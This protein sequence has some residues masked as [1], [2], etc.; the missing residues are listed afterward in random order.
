MR[1]LL[2]LLDLSDEDFRKILARGIEHAGNRKLAPAA[3]ADRTVTLLFEKTS[4]RTRLSFSVAV[5][6]MGGHLIALESQMLQV[7]RGE[8]IEDTTEV[9]ARYVDCVMVRTHSHRRLELMSGLNRIPVINGLS[10]RHHPCQGLADYMTIQEAGRD[11][12]GLC[13]AFVGEPNNVFNSLAL[14]ALHSGSRI[15]L[16]APDGYPIRPGIRDHLKKKNVHLE[17]FRDPAEAVKEADVIYTD[18]WVSMGQEEEAEERKAVFRPYRIDDELLSKARKDVMVMHCLPAHRGEEI[19]D[20]VM[21]AHGPTI[22][23]QAENRLH[24]QKAILEWIFGLI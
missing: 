20:S 5:M 23:K 9:L 15:H 21:D 10:D 13:I 2:S 3:L 14:G 11:L 12:K 18:T 16:A 7:G 1:H 24:I 19:T 4:T 17:V 6:E 22:F 8:S